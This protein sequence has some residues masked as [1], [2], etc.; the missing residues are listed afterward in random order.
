MSR[1]TTALLAL[2]AMGVGAGGFALGR[3]SASEREVP[4]E[5]R[6]AVPPHEVP[7]WRRSAEALRADPAAG[8]LRERALDVLNDADGDVALAQSV[9]MLGWVAQPEDHDLLLSLALSGDAVLEAPGLEALGRLG[10]DRAVDT[11]LALLDDRSV[12]RAAVLAALGHTGHPDALDELVRR[13]QHPHDA[14]VAAWSLAQFATPRAVHFLARALRDADPQRAG[15]LARAL[16]SMVDDV[17]EAGDA[18]HRVLNGPRDPRRAAALAALA[19]A[20]DPLVYDVLMADLDGP[21]PTAAQAAVS[22]GT[23]GDPRA[24]PRLADLA[25]SGQAQVRGAALDAL[26][27]LDHADAD[28]ALLDIVAHA[29]PTVA[30]RAVQSLPRLD[31]PAVIDALLAAI[32]DRPTDV[33]RAAL[34]RLL[35]GSWAVGEVP[36]AVLELAR[37]ELRNPTANAWGVDPVGLLLQHGTPDDAQL[38]ARALT[39]GPTPVRTAAVWSLQQLGTPAARDLLLRLADD[40][41]INVRQSALNALLELGAED[42]VERMVLDQLGRGVQSFGSP[43]D[44]LVRL[45]TPRAVDAVIRRVE[46]GTQR[47]WSSAVSALAASGSRQHS[48]QLLAIADRTDDP[49]LRSHI[50]QALSYSETVDLDRVVDRALSVDDPQLH[51]TA[52]YGLARMG[53]PESRERLLGMTRD[54]DPT[55]ASA[56]LSSL[57]TLG[58]DDAEA[59]L[60][61]ALEDPDLAWTAVSS[62]QQ[63]GTPSAHRALL[64]AS[65]TASDPQVRA[66]LV[67]QLP[68]IGADDANQRLDAAL[69]D[70]DAQV[71][72]AAISGLQGLGTTQA[73]QVLADALSA[74]ELGDS[75][76]EHAA[77]VLRDMGG[78]VAQANADLIEAWLPEG[79]DTGLV[80]WPMPH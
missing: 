2:C 42:E 30:A 78:E 53:T 4:V 12:D 35:G 11:L 50:L 22:L 9:A 31:E 40:T 15:A 37:I 68:W 7:A 8:P 34:Q 67:Q 27:R 17:P 32:T 46:T 55:V 74:G 48:E 43:E 54:A 6:L 41:D 60:V 25:V 59:A 36:D 33:R 44:L 80:E 77:R 71:R 1:R 69:D 64:D 57:G 5:E 75:E 16:A 79:A 3:W 66:S 14:W 49:Q 23:L 45:G 62:L 63:V 52:A 70:A 47:E 20:H 10:T 72:T 21:A 56:A 38:V 61:E 26:S 65:E 19:E 58:G 18:L 51:A 28:A 73:A 13:L 29:P 24:V 39:E 76:A